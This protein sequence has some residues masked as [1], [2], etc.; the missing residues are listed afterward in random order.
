MPACD[1]CRHTLA[2]SLKLWDLHAHVFAAST[3]APGAVA[4]LAV[5]ESGIFSMHE[6]HG[7]VLTASKDG[8]CAVCAL[9][10]GGLARKSRYDFALGK[11]KT[12]RWRDAA[13]FA[14]AGEGNAVA[15]VDVRGGGGGGGCGATLKLEMKGLHDHG[16]QDLRWSPA[17]EHLLLS[18]GS[19]TTM[20]LHDVR[21]PG[22]AVIRLHGH[23]KKVTEG[24]NVF[25]P[26]F[27]HGGRAVSCLGQ[28]SNRLTLYSAAS[29]QR[30]WEATLRDASGE[31]RPPPKKGAQVHAFGPQQASG[32]GGAAGGSG[33]EEVLLVTNG[34]YVDV[35]VPKW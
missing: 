4:E 24:L 19:D 31:V 3:R 14:C 27:S 23:A 2:R 15:M 18:S 6:L 8:T 10:A 30:V 1:D 21:Y 22:A 5:H 17:C 12:A 13:T 25:T 33:E 16:L 11:L 28:D 34:K 9:T 35:H 20:G 29:G 26:C 7:S 32:G